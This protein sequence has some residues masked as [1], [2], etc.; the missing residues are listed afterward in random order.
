MSRPIVALCTRAHGHVQAMLPVVSELCARGREVLVYTDAEFAAWIARAGATPVDLDARYPIEAV[1]AASRPLPCRYVTF[2]AHYGTALAE[3]IGALDPELILYETFMVAGP[4]VARRLGLPYVNVSPNHALVPQRTLA[5]LRDDPRVSI[6]PVCYRAV[7]RL[8]DEFGH[9]E[10]HPFWYA[11]ALS[12]YL[13]LYSE[14]AQFLAD[15]D[16]A[17]FAPLEF[18]G[19]LAPH[20]RGGNPGAFHSKGAMQRVLVSFGTVLWRYYEAQALAALRAIAAAFAGR[21]AEVVISLGGHPLPAAEKAA[22]ARGNVAVLDVVDQWATLQQADVFVT[23]HGINSTHEAIFHQ[24]PMLSLPF[25]ADQ[26]DLARR[27]NELGL[28]IPLGRGA[29][30]DLRAA[31]VESA[32]ARLGREGD[33]TARCLAAARDWEV[34]LIADRPAVVDRVLRVA[35]GGAI[36]AATPILDSRD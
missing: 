32:L 26:P 24:V 27:C 29:P 25:F 20:L 9:P 3:E 31:D 35:T 11:D 1:D 10:A 23:H 30:G 33:H 5:A 8:R 17:V 7:E 34:R 21:D 4:V 12:P 28:A 2:A 18:F 19:C 15:A 16:R 14:P 6:S 13:N 22:I 36:G